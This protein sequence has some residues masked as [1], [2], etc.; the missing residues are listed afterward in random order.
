MILAEVIKLSGIK[1]DADKV[2]ERVELISRDYEDPAEVVRYYQS[3]PQLLRGIE[4][5][6][7][8]DLVVD[9]VESQA[10]ISVIE[11]TFDEVMNPQPGA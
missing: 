3:N 10:K 7:M 4:T 9:W 2:R 1:M 11:K 6:V 8:E 5:L